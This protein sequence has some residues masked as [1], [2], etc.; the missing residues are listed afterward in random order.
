MRIAASFCLA[1]V[2]S[3]CMSPQV[4]FEQEASRHA[5]LCCDA[6]DTYTT[7]VPPLGLAHEV[8]AIRE[9]VRKETKDGFVGQ[10]HWFSRGQA[11][12]CVTDGCWEVLRSSDGTWFTGSHWSRP[13]PPKKGEKYVPH[14]EQ[15]TVTS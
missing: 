3:S 1:W 2:L 12:V 9:I 6:L 10:I 11:L 13:S 5:K 14:R 4:V 15:I 7:P 8:P